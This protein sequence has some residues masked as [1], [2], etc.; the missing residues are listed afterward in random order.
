MKRVLIIAAS[1]SGAGAGVQADLKTC[2]ALGCYATTA[3]TALTA[4]NTQGVKSI[5]PVESG[6]V[7]DQIECV[8]ED[9]GADS[10]KIGM[11]LNAKIIETVSRVLRKYSIPIILDPVMI[12]QSGHALL[13]PDA[14]FA[15][16]EYLF[17]QVF[18][19]TP[20]LDEAR[21]LVGE[22]EVEI[23]AQKILSMG[24]QAVLVKGGH[25]NQEVYAEARDYLLQCS[26]SSQDL[27]LNPSPP[28]GEGL[29]NEIPPL[30]LL[31]RGVGGEVPQE[32]A[33][34]STP[35][36]QTKNTHGTG[37]TLSAAI[38]SYIALGFELKD[39]ISQAKS[40]L[41]GALYRGVHQVIGQG[42]GPVCHNWRNS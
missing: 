3:M 24:V 25:R 34:F 35:W 39:A 27:T 37:C 18:L 33:Y 7:A 15:L 21:V 4:Q 20:N 10:I 30:Q 38:A 5:F 19:L 28:S 26:S 23:A 14:V 32:G 6:F 41:T 1:D 29:G 22:H 9:I 42:A 31:E 40:Y 16:R 2:F 36:I 17:P 8:L 12:S 13:E 11:L